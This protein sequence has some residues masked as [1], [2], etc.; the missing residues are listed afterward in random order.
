MLHATGVASG[1]PDTPE[2]PRHEGVQS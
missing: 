1:S 2:A